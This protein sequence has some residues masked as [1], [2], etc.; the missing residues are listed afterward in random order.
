MSERF[1]AIASFVKGLD[2][3]RSPLAMPAGTLTSILNGFI[4][5][6]GEIEQRKSLAL[7]DTFGN[8]FGVEAISIGLVS[9]YYNTVPHV[10]AGVTALQCVP[11]AAYKYTSNGTQ[12]TL[13]AVPYSCNFNGKAFVLATFT[14]GKTFAFYG[15]ASPM[16]LV[17]EVGRYGVVLYN[18]AGIETLNN[19]A[20]DLAETLNTINGF[21]ATANVDENG[22]AID[23]NVI[24]M[25]TPGLHTGFVSPATLVSAAGTLT[26]YEIDQDKPG[27]PSS[28]AGV[29]F[30][31]GKTAGA[32]TIDLQAPHNSGGGG[33]ASIVG[34]VINAGIGGLSGP[35][36]SAI[37]AA[38]NANT[39]TNGGYTAKIDTNNAAKVLV[40]AP[41]VWGALANAFNLTVNV[42]GTVTATAN[43]IPLTAIVAPNP[44]TLQPFTSAGLACAVSGSIGAPSYQW[45][46]DLSGGFFSNDYIAKAGG[47]SFVMSPSGAN[48][49]ILGGSNQAQAPLAASCVV[50]DVGGTGAVTTAHFSV[51]SF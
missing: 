19:L 11:P 1:T 27:Q 38:V 23:G 35:V 20:T 8:C 26:S 29:S 45:F 41:S 31:V 25:T 24:L 32:G 13:S 39:A 36:A 30:T 34:G 4:N 9:F 6:G 43:S 22:T 33:T 10:P 21:T 7:T 14:N 17:G 51:R 48:C 37:V 2:S 12:I 44:L 16:A 15:S 50:T 28:S 46:F 18:S 40:Y 3:R 47:S 49:S 5:A 42:T